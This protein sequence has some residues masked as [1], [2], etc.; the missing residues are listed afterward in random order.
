MTKIFL[1]VILLVGAFAVNAEAWFG[2]KSRGGY[3]YESTFYNQGSSYIDLLDDKPTDVISTLPAD[4]QRI[5]LQRYKGILEDNIIDIRIALG[6][7]DWTTGR[8]VKAEGQNYGFSP[9]LD[10]GAFE[11]LKDLLTSRCY[12]NSRFC[13]FKIDPN[14][15]NRFSREVVIN[16]KTYVARIDMNFGSQ[17]EYLDDNRFTN[18]TAQTQR[19]TFMD[20]FFAR[21]LQNADAI[22]Y[23]GHSR[24]GGGPDFSPPIFVKGLNKVDYAGYYKPN[25]PGLKKMVAALSNGKQAPIIGLMSCASRDHFLTKLKTIAPNSGIITSMDVLQVEVVYTA[26]IGGVDAILRG[27]CQSSFYQSLRMTDDNR[28][29][30]TM[31]GMFE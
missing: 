2:R 20:D 29:Y 24:N 17:T 10:L 12:G 3:L 28:E 23:F 19:T 27:Q 31:D 5:C 7:F 8:I 13:G 25:R 15:A 26:M 14:N 16:G 9:S 21:G 30:I 11:A 1:S 4:K 22:F 6:Y 18:K